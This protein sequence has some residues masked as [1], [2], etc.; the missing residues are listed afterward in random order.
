LYDLQGKR[1]AMVAPVD[2]MAGDHTF[3][4][5][6]PALNLPQANYFYELSVKNDAGIYHQ[7]KRMTSL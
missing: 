3:T 7:C 5:D 6:L 2:L 1:V 4:V